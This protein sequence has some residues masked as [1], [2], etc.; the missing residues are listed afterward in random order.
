MRI[1]TIGALVISLAITPALA[2]KIG[3]VRFTSV[4]IKNKVVLKL[5]DR[6]ADIH[7]FFKKTDIIRPKYRTYTVESD[8]SDVSDQHNKIVAIQFSTYGIVSDADR[9]D[10]HEVVKC[11]FVDIQNGQ[12]LFESD[13]QMCDGEWKKPTLWQDSSGRHLDFERLPK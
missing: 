7:L 5:I 3:N 4:P 13:A 2:A 6:K 9:N 8:A 1:G 10:F 11:A 12:F